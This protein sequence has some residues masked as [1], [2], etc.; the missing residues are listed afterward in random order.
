MKL[1]ATIFWSMA[2]SAT[3]FSVSLRYLLKGASRMYLMTHYHML[4]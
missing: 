1:E 3:L 4:P 2:H